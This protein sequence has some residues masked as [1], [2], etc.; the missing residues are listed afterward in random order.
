MAQWW[1]KQKLYLTNARGTP[2]IVKLSIL[3][4]KVFKN[5]WEF[6]FLAFSHPYTLVWKQ[7]T[8]ICL[9]WAHLSFQ[10]RFEWEVA[11]KSRKIVD[12]S[13][14]AQQMQNYYW[15]IQPTHQGVPPE[16]VVS[17]KHRCI[18]VNQLTSIVN[19]CK[20]RTNFDAL[21]VFFYI[22]YRFCAFSCSSK[23]DY[24]PK[25]GSD[26][27]IVVSKSSKLEIDSPTDSALAISAN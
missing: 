18:G 2:F 9:I 3:A 15:I 16:V 8:T 19:I 1:Q 12:Q 5:F 25:T 22:I 21:L 17:L 10:S 26:L 6:E 13:Q 4:S 23:W 27:S 24:P 20:E 14:N 7:S 11:Q